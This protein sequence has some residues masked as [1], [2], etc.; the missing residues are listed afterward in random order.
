MLTG[1]T[2]LRGVLPAESTMASTINMYSEL[3]FPWESHFLDCWLV[4]VTADITLVVRGSGPKN[5]IFL[6]GPKIIS[7]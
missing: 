4:D 3:R 1:I 7:E 6:N 5:V 2:F